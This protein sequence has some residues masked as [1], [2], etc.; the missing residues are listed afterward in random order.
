MDTD[1]DIHNNTFT[2]FYS[3]VPILARKILFLHLEAVMKFYSL[4]VVL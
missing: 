4:H 3:F 2:D 1:R